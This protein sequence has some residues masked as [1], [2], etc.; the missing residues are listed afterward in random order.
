MKKI[1]LYFLFGF[2]II[3]MIHTK[4][5]ITASQNAI[6]LWSATLLPSFLFPLILIKLLAPYHLLMPFIKPFDFLFI[7]LFNINAYGIESI[8]T[9]LLLGFPGSSIF[10]EQAAI[11]SRL[12]QK[13]YHRLLGCVFM[14]SPNFIL[15]SLSTIHSHHITSS[16]LTIQ[17]C[18]VFIMLLCTRNIPIYI[19]PSFSNTSLSTQM[20]TA[21]QS[22]IEILLM[23][24]IYLLIIY[25]FTDLFTI[26][27]NKQIKTPL[28]LLSEFSSG[29]FYLSSLSFPTTITFI[30]TNTL[31]S[32]GGLCV[33]LQL[34][35]SLDKSKFNYSIFL[36]YRIFHIALSILLSFCFGVCV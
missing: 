24:L 28:K 23:I 12:N 34:L 9:S 11:T 16:L 1:T 21:I 20:K 13:A 7:K 5:T 17:L 35:S 32:Y 10:L 4:T 15:L 26:F 30:M 2:L 8:L 29:C 31:L 6:T 19:Q 22:S 14:A 36:S 18:C 33:H 25:V 3:S 27:M